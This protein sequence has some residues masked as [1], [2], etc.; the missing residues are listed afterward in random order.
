MKTK[1]TGKVIRLADYGDILTLK[2]LSEILGVCDKTC[3][4][5]LKAGKIDHRRIGK[6]YKIYKA[7]LIKFL[8]N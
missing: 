3:R 8:E 6:Q 4:G 5:L 7:S 1:E 2:Q